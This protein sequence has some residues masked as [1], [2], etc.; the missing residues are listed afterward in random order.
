MKL[1][2]TYILITIALLIIETL[3]AMYLKSGFIRH[4]FGDFLVVIL[5]YCFFKSFIPDNHFKIALSVL[6]FAFIIEFLQ[7]VN[8]LSMLNLQNNHLI[9]IVLGSTFQ[10][11][12][13]VAYI[14]GIIT[15]LI[16]EFKL[17]KLWIT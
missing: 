4:T 11:S 10:I 13:L 14:L 17:Y 16:A 9:K 2:K 5:M 1:N 12:D 7:L 15:V 6:A 3:I 8:I